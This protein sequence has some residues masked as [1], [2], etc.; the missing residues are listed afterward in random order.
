MKIIE[1]KIEAKNREIILIDKFNAKRK[2]VDDEMEKYGSSD[3]K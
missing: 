2:N 3:S 1:N